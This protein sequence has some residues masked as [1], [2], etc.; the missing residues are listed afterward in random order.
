MGS[1]KKKMI[2]LEE[3]LTELIQM[4]NQGFV[5]FQMNSQMNTEKMKNKIEEKKKITLCYVYALE[6]FIRCHDL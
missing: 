3:V 5:A 6:T 4:L 2:L 1:K